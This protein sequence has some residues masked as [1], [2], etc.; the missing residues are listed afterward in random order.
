M[1]G[2]YLSYYTARNGRETRE[3]FRHRTLCPGRSNYATRF[4]RRP[5]NVSQRERERDSDSSDI[6][7]VSKIMR[8]SLASRL[9]LSFLYC[10]RF[11]MRETRGTRS[12]TRSEQTVPRDSPT[13]EG[14]EAEEEEESGKTTRDPRRRKTSST[15]TRN[16]NDGRD[17]GA[18]EFENKI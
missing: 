7:T 8:G 17:G 5:L 4:N 15:V 2:E 11:S 12:V 1:S 18:G 14:G 3:I 6:T 16:M 9:K 10:D 13:E